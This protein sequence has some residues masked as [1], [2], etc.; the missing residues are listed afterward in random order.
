M[1]FVPMSDFGKDHWSLL[2]YLETRCVDFKGTIDH[3]H[4]RCNTK[5]HPGLVGFRC[6]SLP[7]PFHN[8]GSYKYPSM[9]KP[10]V[11]V[12]PEHDDWDCFY[13]L[14]EAKLIDDKG[15]GIEPVAVMTELGRRVAGE[16]RKWLAARH[17]YSTFVPGAS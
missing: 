4:L 10:G 11:P 12:V 17:S 1:R 2:A 16:I 7:P 8:D 6:A 13:D 9:L 14:E 15:T 5:T 3:E